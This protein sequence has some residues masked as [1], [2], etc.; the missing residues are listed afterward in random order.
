MNGVWV[1]A[2]FSLTG[3]VVK[4]DS[5]APFA[6]T[7]GQSGAREVTVAGNTGGNPFEVTLRIQNDS[8]PVF[9]PLA[10]VALAQ[11]VTVEVTL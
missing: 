5:V 4:A 8:S 7:T 2:D 1:M 9:D 11:E 3:N 10:Q 6:E